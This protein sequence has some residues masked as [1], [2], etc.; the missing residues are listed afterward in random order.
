[1]DRDLPYP[2]PTTA[3]ASRIMK[4][5]RP[6]NTRPE[7][8]LRS[9]LHRAG[10]RFRKDLY[11]QIPTRARGARPDIAFLGARLAVF[12]DG[13]FWHQCPQHGHI[14]TANRGYWEPKLERNAN[15]DREI[16]RALA[17][18]GWTVIRVWEHVPVEASAARVREA[19]GLNVRTGL[20]Q[21]N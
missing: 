18:S 15:R 1:M 17:A 20:A 3:G 16:D 11:V 13:C 14:P 12:V 2:T 5:N 21:S 8:A 4:G 6:F 7:I 9:T 10:L 19:L